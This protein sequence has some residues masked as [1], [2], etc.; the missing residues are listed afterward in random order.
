MMQPVAVVVLEGI[1]LKGKWR[2]EWVNSTLVNRWLPWAH[3][4]DCKCD[5][6]MTYSCD[7]CGRRVGWCLGGDDNMRGACDF[8][9]TAPKGEDS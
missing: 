4:P 9:W 6:T 3:A 7:R 8:C 1:S 2:R 5:V